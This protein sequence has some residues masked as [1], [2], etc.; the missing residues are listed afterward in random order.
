M[1]DKIQLWLFPSERFYLTMFVH[2]LPF[3]H[4]PPLHP[5]LPRFLLLSPRYCHAAP[6]AVGWEGVGLACLRLGQLQDAREAL[7][8]ANSYDS[9][10]A[11]VGEMKEMAEWERCEGEV[12][13]HM[14]VCNIWRE[15]KK[16]ETGIEGKSNNF[17]FSF[18]FLL[19][20][21]FFSSLSPLFSSFFF[22]TLTS[23]HSLYIVFFSSS[24]SFLPFSYSLS[25]GVG[26]PCR[27]VCS[28]TTKGG[29][30]AVLQ[31]CLETW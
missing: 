8:E 18:E 22:S 15:R 2:Y 5:Y 6:S 24:R 19:F 29:G 3:F 31:V 7:A 27:R 16:K 20:S 23:L 28:I 21:F 4:S 13:L 30:G 9:T 10:N 11:K 25:P 14:S 12:S 26:I 17:F 1:T